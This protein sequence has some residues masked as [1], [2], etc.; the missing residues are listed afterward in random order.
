MSGIRTIHFASRDPYAGSI[1]LLGTT[2]YLQRKHIQVTHYENNDFEKILIAIH[3]A[4]IKKRDGSG[5]NLVLDQWNEVFEDYVNLGLNEQ[6]SNYLWNNINTP[7]FKELYDHL[8]EIS[9]GI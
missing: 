1:N 7:N 5:Q 4:Y 2:P 6:F 8:C 9:E 3:T